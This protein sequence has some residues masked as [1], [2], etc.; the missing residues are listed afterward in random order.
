MKEVRPVAAVVPDCPSTSVL[1][2]NTLQVYTKTRFTATSVGYAGRFS[3]LHFYVLYLCIS[4]FILRDRL[5]DC[6]SHRGLCTKNFLVLLR[7]T[8]I[9]K[10]TK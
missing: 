1:S 3:V 7:L 8:N 2:A 5:S 9:D 4:L 6:L 10:Q